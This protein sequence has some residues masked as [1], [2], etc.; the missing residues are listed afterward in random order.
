M[1]GLDVNSYLYDIEHG[2][3]E[4]LQ[5]VA[6]YTMGS[7]YVARQVIGRI[8]TSI[9]QLKKILEDSYNLQNFASDESKINL[10]TKL[11]N[12]VNNNFLIIQSYARNSNLNSDCERECN[13]RISRFEAAITG[14]VKSLNKKGMSLD[15]SKEKTGSLPK[16]GEPYYVEN[17]SPD[18]PVEF[19]IIESQ[20]SYIENPSSIN[21]YIGNIVN[22]VESL[23]KDSIFSSNSIG[24]QLLE[25]V[26]DNANNIKEKL[27][28]IDKE[29]PNRIQ[30]HIISQLMDRMQNKFLLSQKQLSYQS[31][32]AR[33]VSTK[34]SIS[35]IETN[36]IELAKALNKIGMS[37]DLDKFTPRF[38]PAANKSSLEE[39]GKW[40]SKSKEEQ[41]PKNNPQR[42][43]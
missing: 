43:R 23:N 11:V 35:K 41:S 25:D 3:L 6:N 16:Q 7:P 24:S 1:D 15:L 2:G 29:N 19:R 32:E 14:V 36:V 21:D 20:Q 5:E 28:E 38:I 31:S 10:I 39:Y 17:W 4:K 8:S 18:R 40:S 13:K 26:R 33:D 42:I 22:Q 27:E 30:E 34:D 12:K 9:S 37:L